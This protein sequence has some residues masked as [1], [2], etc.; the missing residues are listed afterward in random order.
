MQLNVLNDLAKAKSRWTESQE[1][2]D[3]SVMTPGRQRHLSAAT[4]G[5]LWYLLVLCTWAHEQVLV[6]GL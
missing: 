5:V 2:L 4:A 1:P 3:V 6:R